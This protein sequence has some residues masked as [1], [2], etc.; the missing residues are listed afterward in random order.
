LA[1]IITAVVL[2]LKAQPGTPV[3]VAQV[4]DNDPN[5]KAQ[6][7]E[8]NPKFQE[9]KAAPAPPAAPEQS[10]E[11][12]PQKP[13]EAATGNAPLVPPPDPKVAKSPDLAPAQAPA[14]VPAEPGAGGGRLSVEMLQHLKRATVFIK[15][16]AGKLSATGSGFVMK[17]EGETA[18]IITNHHVVDPSAEML[19]LGPGGRIQTVK[20]RAN[21]AVILAIFRSGTKE[22]RALNAEVMASDPSRDLAVLKVNDVKDFAQAIDLDQKAQLVETMPVYILGFPFGKALSM[23]KGNPNITINKGSVS[24]LRENDRGQMKAVQIDGALNPGNSGGP[25]VDDQGRLVGVAVATI[26][27]SGIGLAIAPEELTHLFQGRVGGVS[28]TKRPIVNQTVTLDLEA[29][30]ID[31]MNKIRVVSLRWTRKNVNRPKPQPDNAGFFPPLADGQDVELKIEGQKATGKLELPLKDNEGYD[32]EYQVACMNGSGKLMYT[33]AATFRVDSQFNRPPA[34]AGMQPNFPQGVI[35]A[36]PGPGL[37]KTTALNKP[38]WATAG[39]VGEID[40]KEVPLPAENILPCLCW[41][42]KP[43]SFCVLT[44]NGMLSRVRLNDFEMPESKDI[45]RNCS[46]LTMSARGPIVTVDGAQEAWILDSSFQVTKKLAMAGV[47]QVVSAPTLTVAIAANTDRFAGGLS[48]I[49]LNKGAFAGQHRFQELGLI[50]GASRLAVTPDGK[51]L[52][53][54]GGFEDLK[55]F[56]IS[57]TR[58]SADQT[59]ARIAQNGQSIAISPD[60]KY[61][62]LPSGGGNYGA[63]TYTTF[64]Y[65][66]TNLSQ[67]QIMVS[68]GAYPRAM[69]FDPIAGLIYTQNHDKQLLIYDPSGVRLKEFTLG[70]TG[71]VKQFL[72]HPDG[73]KVLVLTDRKLYFV[74]VGA[75]T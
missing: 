59:S 27:G 9:A 16:E 43:E 18:Y 23:N 42:K 57:G 29:Q 15:R 62:S 75:S 6:F 63:G 17:I 4:A 19:R 11:A 5:G 1:G 35:Q 40:V 36:R 58:I 74:R 72:V 14:G 8:P 30:L 33:D 25:V 69:G 20:V 12:K 73:R 68:S 10:G 53:M 54:Q 22:E 55:C 41:D 45:A 51:Y 47:T 46:W 32:I 48:V 44:R 34:I 7:Q 66:V 39:T 38:L 37:E 71:D 67:P 3:Q 65:S 70:P 50:A 24:S 2:L 64:I 31:P 49:D 60:S 52:F 61:V 13:A 26:E 28:L 56:R 21:G